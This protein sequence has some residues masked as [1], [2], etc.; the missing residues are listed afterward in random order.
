LREQITDVIVSL[1]H[2]PAARERLS[3]GLVERFVRVGPDSYNDIRAM[4]EA[5]EE[6][7]FM[8]L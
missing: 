1:H 3:S 6:S 5:C 7:G 8:T 2:D 4:L